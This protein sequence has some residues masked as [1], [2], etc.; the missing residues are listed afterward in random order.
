MDVVVGSAGLFE[1]AKKESGRL[2]MAWEI[3]R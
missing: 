2:G 3:D 1:H